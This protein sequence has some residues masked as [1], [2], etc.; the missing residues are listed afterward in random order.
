MSIQRPRGAGLDPPKPSASED[1]V[2][3][4]R[5]HAEEYALVATV[6]LSMLPYVH[7]DDLNLLG[8][9]I[10]PFGLLVAAAVYAGVKLAKR[11]ARLSGL[12]MAELEAFIGWMLVVGFVCA[13]VLDEIL[14]R[15]AEVLARPWTLLYVWQGIGSFSG[16][17]GALAGVVLWR[18]YRWRERWTL[19]PWKISALEKRES[20]M[21]ILPFADTVL[22]VFPVAWILGRSGCSIVHDH[23]GDLASNGSPLAVEFPAVDPNVTDGPGAHASFGPLTI[24]HGQHPRYDLGTLELFFT[25]ALATVCV[26]LWRKKLMTGAYVVLACL[27]YA[28]ARFLM[29]FLRLPSNDPRYLGLTPAQWMSIGLFVAGLA[30]LRRIRR[31]RLELH[32]AA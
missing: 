3:S 5:V 1:R 27:A 25:L 10:H 28:P 20:P 32:R 21:P 29:E 18:R 11:R 14:Y 13:H 6:P 15:P 31:M 7:V 26:I 22:S 16:W 8:L 24:I 19:G 9:H 23:P 17:L 12:D 2:E 30:L 4:K